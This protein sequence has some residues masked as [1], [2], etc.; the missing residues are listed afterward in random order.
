VREVCKST[1][2]STG[3]GSIKLNASN[4]LRTPLIESYLYSLTHSIQDRIIHQTIDN[5]AM[6]TG[7]L[8]NA[9]NGQWDNKVGKQSTMG[10]WTLVQWTHGRLDRGTVR[11]EQWGIGEAHT[12]TM[13]Q[14]GNGAR[15]PRS[16]GQCTLGQ[17]HGSSALDER[18]TE[19]QSTARGFVA[20][21][22]EQA[23]SS[24]SSNCFN[25]L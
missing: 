24:M 25:D 23:H 6:D 4:N 17:C 5:A 16:T 22:R 14:W 21:S 13:E 8:G 3:P 11:M 9:K 7:T 1:Q 19:H 20:A 2:E 12:G 10:P 15:G 18:M